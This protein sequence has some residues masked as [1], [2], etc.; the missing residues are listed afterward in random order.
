VGLLEGGKLVLRSGSSTE[1]IA[2][3]VGTENRE[4]ARGA[5]TKPYLGEERL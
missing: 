5:G 2:E 3:N 4:T 1:R